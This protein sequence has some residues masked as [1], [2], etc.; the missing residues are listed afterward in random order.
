MQ[1]GAVAGGEPVDPT[2]VAHFRILGR[3]GQGG[4]G[5]VYRAEDETL[6]RTVALKLLPD[7]GEDPEVRQ[8]FLREARSAAAI[9][10]P[11]VATVHQVGEAD[12]RLFIAMEL[13]P[14]ENLR[15]RLE[16]GRLDVA[17]ARDLGGQMARG[18]A[19][20]H[21]KGIVHRDLKPENVMIT[22]AGVVKILDFGLAKLGPD[23]P[24]SERADGGQA[25][26]ATRVT[27]DRTRI[28]GTPEYMS[29]EQAVG[30][31]MDVRSDVFSFGVVLY[32]MLAGTRPFVG[33]TSGKLILA[34]ARD[35]APPLRD[36]VPEIDVATE[37][38]VMRCLEKAPA[39]RFANGEQVVRAL[40]ELSSTTPLAPTGPVTRVTASAPRRRLSGVGL[41]AAT[42]VAAAIA[43]GS[44]IVRHPAH[45]AGDPRRPA[46]APSSSAL[47]VTRIVDL[48]PPRT[49]VPAAAAEFASGIQA[50]HDDNWTKAQAHFAK[51]VELDPSMAAAH[52]RLSMTFNGFAD[53]VRRRAEF[54]KAAGLRAQLGERDEA[55]LEALQPLLQ[56][57]TQ[58]TVETDRRLR[59]LVDRYPTDVEIWLWLSLVNRGLPEGLGPAERALALDPGDA[60][61]WENKGWALLAAGKVDEAHAAFERCGALSVDGADCFLWMG[62]AD[63]LAGRCAEFEQDAR[64]AADRNPLGLAVVLWAMTSTGSSAE[65]AQET[66]SQLIPAIPASFGPELQRLGYDTRLAI[67]AGDLARA[68][69]LAQQA[70]AILTADPSLR[71]RYKARYQL[72]LQRVDIALEI[73]DEGAARRLAGD[74][75]ARSGAWQREIYND[76]GV[77]L[78]L[79]LARLTLPLTEPAPPAFEATRRAWVNARLAEGA[80]RGQVWNYA[81]ASPAFTASEARAALEAMD[82]MGPWTPT[83]V[84]A[85]PFAARIGSPEADTGRV[86][87]LAGR[88]DE[89]IDHLRRAT[90]QCDILSSTLDHVR[91]ELHLGRALEQTGDRAGACDAYGRVLA[92]WGH[93]SP[94]SVTADEARARVKAI[95]CAA[96]PREPRP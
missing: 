59:A 61:S 75:A 42:L 41:L 13:V 65:A 62:W 51:A 25:K 32:E 50:M 43:V 81:Y 53:P 71:S 12:G 5:V 17:T 21:V 96:G 16:R 49:S 11:N 90:A 72:T 52:L 2:T 89:A 26:T 46:V 34:I 35:P 14:G 79:Y 55:L 3:L 86:Y 27:T 24:L 1:V 28:L 64:K 63:S 10:D 54:E 66:V 36:R 39:S 37:A 33:P 77:D 30:D 68:D 58:D 7:T 93:A 60:Q 4:M 29:P 94:R 91:A 84:A 73:G 95:G 44:W 85:T 20:A 67:V 23:G 56:R 87:L 18:L 47:A 45:S 48:P 70:S 40:S 76:H 74:F 8:R 38:V 78:S 9:A 31:P 88:A 57:Q 83:P 19:A 22:P 69:S 80:F 82:A 6:R 15:E 92:R